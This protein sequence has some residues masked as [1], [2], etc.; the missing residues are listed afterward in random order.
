MNPLFLLHELILRAFERK[1]AIVSL[2]LL[3]LCST[4]CGIILVKTP[5]F[6]EYH[7]RICDRF[8]DRVC[9]SDRSVV[10]IFF[11]RCAGNVLILLLLLAGGIHPAALVL[12]TTAIA[13]RA[14]TFG[15]TLAILFSVYNMAGAMVAFTLFLPIHLLIDCI[16]LLAGSISFSRAFCFRFTS[17]DFRELLFDFLLLSGLIVLVC[18]LEGILLGVLFHPIGN[19]L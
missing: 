2:F 6:Y 8:L 1:W 13:F 5:T 14:Y 18:L 19:I 9:Y 10:L 11:E 12:P 4:M 3:V 16:F 15:G 7:L 17:S